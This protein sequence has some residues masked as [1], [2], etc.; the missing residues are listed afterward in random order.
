MKKMEKHELQNF[1]DEV[2]KSFGAKLLTEK[3]V[4]VKT[5]EGKIRAM[6]EETFR[7]ASFFR[8]VMNAGV[9]VAKQRKNF[10]TL[11]I[12]GCKFVS[13]L[14]GAHVV[15]L[16]KEDAVKWMR[17]DPVNVG[18]QSHKTVIGRYREHLLGTAVV[19]INGVAYPQVPKW[20]RLPPDTS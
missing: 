1:A 6:T 2:L 16:T 15:E 8:G 19:D 18:I 4:F 11:T 13:L 20:R 7:A 5:G 3:H 17:G 10:V 9:Y 12:E 14:P